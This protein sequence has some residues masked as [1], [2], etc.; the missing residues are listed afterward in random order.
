MTSRLRALIRSV[1]VATVATAGLTIGAVTAAA[2]SNLVESNPADGDVVAE[3]P[4][5][6]VLTF[7]DDVQ[8]DYTEVAVLYDG[9]TVDAGE[10]VSAGADV[11]QPLVPLPAGTS[12]ADVTVSFRIV[13][14]DGHPVDGTFTFSVESPP[15]ATPTEDTGTEAPRETGSP[16]S[17]PADDAT[18]VATAGA[19]SDD[20]STSATSTGTLVAIGVA[21]AAVI[22]VGGLAA[23]RRLRRDGPDQGP[24]E[25][26][27]I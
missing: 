24:L 19:S 18:P 4:S 17:E 12:T 22:L 15:S 7:S 5:E 14:A 6:V 2:H 3:L 8:P 9:A 20:D 21:V 26:P 16:E 23:R 25:G 13:S 27:T 10:P 1:G 11:T